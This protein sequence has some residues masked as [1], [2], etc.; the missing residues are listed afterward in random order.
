MRSAARSSRPRSGRT[1]GG[2]AGTDGAESGGAG[3]AGGAGGPGGAHGAQ[4]QATAA[5]SPVETE[6]NGLA[7]AGLRARVREAA[8]FGEPS[9]TARPRPA[10]AK[11]RWIGLTALATLI[12]VSGFAGATLLDRLGREGRGAGSGPAPSLLAA[13]PASPVAPYPPAAAGTVAPP[14]SPDDAESDPR[15]TG[16]FAVECAPQGIEPVP[17]E[18]QPATPGVDPVPPAHGDPTGVPTGAPADAMAAVPRHAF[19][20]ETIGLWIASVPEGAMVRIAGKIVGRTPW[21]GRRR[22]DKEDLPVDLALE[23]HA[24]ATFS[25][26]AD[27]DR[28]ETRLL[29][30]LPPAPQGR[31]RH[32]PKPARVLDDSPMRVIFVMQPW[33]ASD[34]AEVTPIRD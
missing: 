1:G 21:A 29:R 4:P 11:T 17:P 10:P 5:P 27:R 8:V 16:T 18:V 22:N 25:I 26:V 19:E 31:G 32:A 24:R 2:G 9:E 34:S 12:L 30:P 6:T 20:P 23:G 28:A 7:I 3:G 15:P 14:A 33:H 13:A